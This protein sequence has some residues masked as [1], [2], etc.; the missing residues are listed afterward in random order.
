LSD[1]DDTIICSGGYLG[2]TDIRYPW[3]TVYPG[4]TSFYEELDR[5]FAPDYEVEESNLVFLTARPRIIE[6]KTYSKFVELAENFR[7]T[8]KKSISY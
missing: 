3:G 5:G 7:K 8:K 1:I 4:V 6:D 2:G